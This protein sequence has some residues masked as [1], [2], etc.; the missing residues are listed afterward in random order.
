MY[1]RALDGYEKA[2]APEH[3]S[4]LD[5][6]NNLDNLYADQGNLAE[7]EKMY[8]RALTGYK[9]LRGLIQ[10]LYKQCQKASEEVAKA[11]CQ[12]DEE[13]VEKSEMLEGNLLKQ[14]EQ[15]QII[16]EFRKKIMERRERE[17]ELR[18]KLA[19]TETRHKVREA[20]KTGKEKPVSNGSSS[21]EK[22]NT[23]G[24]G[25]SKHLKTI[26]KAS[27]DREFR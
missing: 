17:G 5:T 23:I 24:K 12:G 21:A 6:V 1:R 27:T 2:W 15:S 25:K 19:K 9:K 13:K 16:D 7:A 22:Y 4:T 18:E 8:L 3:T 11:V 14:M 10:D 26:T 20:I